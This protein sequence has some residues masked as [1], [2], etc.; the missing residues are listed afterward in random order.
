MNTP[1]KRFIMPV[2]LHTHT[3][4]ETQKTET[5]SFVQN[6]ASCCI[7]TVIANIVSFIHVCLNVKNCEIAVDVEVLAV[8]MK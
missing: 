6:L 8:L 4:R 7:Y 3:D 2:P 1:K 5:L